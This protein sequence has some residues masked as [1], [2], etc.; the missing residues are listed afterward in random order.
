[1]SKEGS[2]QTEIAQKFGISAQR[3]GQILLSYKGKNL[4]RKAMPFV[5]AASKSFSTENLVS[6]VLDSDIDSNF[7]LKLVEVLLSK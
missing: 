4:K 3:I 2:K 5:N 6:A 7:K 1:M